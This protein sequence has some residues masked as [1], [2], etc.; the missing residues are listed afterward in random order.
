MHKL[1]LGRG[2]KYF[3]THIDYPQRQ[4]NIDMI[5]IVNG[6]KII[7]DNLSSIKS[8]IK[9]VKKFFGRILDHDKYTAS[10]LLLG[11]ALSNLEAG[12]LLSKAGYSEEL[13]ELS[14]SGHESIDLAF[15]FLDDENNNLL[16][17][18]FKG[19][20]IENNIA[21]QFFEKKAH[22]TKILENSIELAKAKS[23]IYKAYSLSTHSQYTALVDLIDV[24]YEDLDF[25]KYSGFHH[26]AIFVYYLQSLYSN[27]LLLLKNIF[28]KK[29]DQSNIDKIDKLL[30][31][32]LPKVPNSEVEQI[33][34][35]YKKANSQ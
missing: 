31:A 8:L 25:Y 26:S 19:E 35:R 7:E 27:I 33:L 30:D 13:L 18:W 11:K 21:R 1:R 20:I 28:V 32:V 4:K 34:K 3:L 24:F 16:I 23:H 6:T 12:I 10:Y 2:K 15:L 22:K 29:I 14:R 17:R 9:E 5:T